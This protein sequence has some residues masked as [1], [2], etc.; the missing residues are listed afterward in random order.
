MSYSENLYPAID[1]ASDFEQ[2]VEQRLCSFRGVRSRDAMPRNDHAQDL[3]QTRSHNQYQLLDDENDNQVTDGYFRASS[4]SASTPYTQ[5]TSSTRPAFDAPNVPNA[6]VPDPSLPPGVTAGS[7]AREAEQETSIY[8]AATTDSP[9]IRT[10]HRLYNPRRDI[11][12]ERSPIIPAEAPPA[13]TPSPASPTPASTRPDP[14]RNYRT[15]PETSI[16]LGESGRPLAREP[17]CM[18]NPNEEPEGITPR[19]REWRRRCKPAFNRP[20]RRGLILVF[21]ILVSVASFLGTAEVMELFFSTLPYAALF[22][23]ASRSLHIFL[24]VLDP[25]EQCFE[26]LLLHLLDLLTPSLA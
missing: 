4:A 23:T 12:S 24:L 9:S 11:Y 25:S 10:P 5:T 13:Y 17:Q 7:K 15:F 16:G 21:V 22:V 18:G 1:D 26:A 3:H 8:L 19:W 20:S 14:T 2:P 6:W